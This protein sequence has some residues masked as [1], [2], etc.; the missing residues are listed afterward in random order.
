[1]RTQRMA[2][3]QKHPFSR[4]YTHHP[5]RIN[6][7]SHPQHSFNLKDYVQSELPESGEFVLTA[8][9]PMKYNIPERVFPHLWYII[10]IIPPRTAKSLC[11]HNGRQNGSNTSFFCVACRC[12]CR[13]G[14]PMCSRAPT[15]STGSQSPR[16]RKL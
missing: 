11:P 5:A 14:F 10:T 4:V 9:W 1:M 15:T 16:T 8:E 3:G 13:H 2:R 7:F 12:V 6:L